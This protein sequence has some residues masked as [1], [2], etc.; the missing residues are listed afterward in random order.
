MQV[1]AIPALGARP[2]KLKLA[3]ALAVLLVASLARADNIEVAG[4]GSLTIPDGSTVTSIEIIPPLDGSIF[5]PT[6]S[7]AYSFADGTG[8]TAGNI[9]IGYIGLI[10]FSTPVSDVTLDWFGNDAFQLTD[11]AGDEISCGDCSGVS[12]LPGSGITQ[13]NWQ[14]GGEEGG[15]ESMSYTLD[16]TDPPGVP[17]PSSLLLTGF[18]LAASVGL[19]RRRRRKGL[20]AMV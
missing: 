20:T 17:E 5:G 2:M 8:T 1:I 14:V 13:I 11:S 6:A 10:D 7:I 4:I 19:A 15:I 16:G 12:T 9:G 3:V 18:G